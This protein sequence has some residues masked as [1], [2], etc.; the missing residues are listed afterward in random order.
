MKDRGFAL[1]WWVSLGV[2]G[3]MAACAT[4]AAHSPLSVP[5]PAASSAGTGGGISELGSFQDHGVPNGVVIWLRVPAA[6][7]DGP[8]LGTLIGVGSMLDPS[9]VLANKLGAPLSRLVDLSKPI[10]L[11]VSGLDD[12]PVRLAL[13]ANIVNSNTFIAQLRADFQIVHKGRGRWQLVPNA[14]STPNA[15]GCELW[16]AAEPVGA[17][18]VCATQPALIEQQGEFFMAAARSSVDRANFHAELPG[19]AARLALQKSADD[20]AR[21]EQQTA[22]NDDAATR[23]GRAL[24]R[25]MITDLGLDLSGISWDLM[26]QRD[27]VE[28][29]QVIGFSQSSSLLSATFSGRVGPPK[30]VPEAFWQLPSD[31]DFSLYSEGA[32][33]EPMRRF[34]ES[35][36]QALRAATEVDNEYELPPAVLDRLTHVV[37][38]S[39]LRGGGFEVAYG[40]DLD[41]AARA[42]KEAAERASDRGPRSGSADPALRK[43]Q[44]ELGGWALLGLEDDSQAFLQALREALRIATDKTPYPRKKGAKPRPPSVSSYE[45]GELPLPPSAG[46]PQEALH[47]VLHTKPNPKYL[48]SKATPP[49]PPPST[50]HLIAVADAAQHLWLVLSLDEA[51]ALARM[52]AVLRP[53]PAKTLGASDELRQLAKQPLA[54]I[55]FG[56]LAG[57]TGLTL[58][59]ESKSKVLA[60]RRSLKRLWA[61]PKR[62]S[63]RL[64]IWI[65]RAELPKG[66]RRIALNLRLNPDAISDILATFIALGADP[67]AAGRK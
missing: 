54:G 2:S 23:S 37:D 62:G 33:R 28:I 46:L 34:A 6:G 12:G 7:R 55:G 35:W 67:V 10:D 11:L 13:A 20:E 65:T 3:V 9:Q 29:S 5:A 51:Q 25:K 16:H 18:L 53:E 43:A 59:A 19:S 15:L 38:S 57:A 66:E 14:K 63:T 30:P 24:G 42:L 45:L 1:R 27:S 52:R 39:L 22:A 26:L 61:L 48:A 47:V 40:V 58:S 4:P 31:S 64:P 50:C 49:A 41:R 60:S 17:R 21:K 32:E 44:A 8:L 36:I 56:T